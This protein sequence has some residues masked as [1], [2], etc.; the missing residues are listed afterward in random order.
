MHRAG[1]RTARGPAGGARS[2]GEA[3]RREA[4]RR[5]QGVFTQ[6]ALQGC[7][8]CARACHA[9]RLQLQGVYAPAPQALRSGCC[10]TLHGAAAAAFALTMR[11]LTP[12]LC[13]RP[14]RSRTTDTTTLRCC[15]ALVAARPC[16][17]PPRR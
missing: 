11:A 6:Q 8:L 5:L 4:S 17:S 16:A 2:R 15:G 10:V 9:R 7:K 1:G 14:V 13:V 3:A 12:V